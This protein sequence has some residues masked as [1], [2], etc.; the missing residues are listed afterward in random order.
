VNQWIVHNFLK[1]QRNDEWNNDDDDDDDEDPENHV[2]DGEE[3]QAEQNLRSHVKAYLL[4]WY[5]GINA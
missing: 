1:T 3:N 5:D 2:H 4:N